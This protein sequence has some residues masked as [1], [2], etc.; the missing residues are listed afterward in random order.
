MD[1]LTHTLFALT[2]ART[3][4]G[5]FGRGT[6][7]ALVLAS[8]APDIDII[9]ASRGAVSY[10]EWHRGPTHGPLA[11]I[12]LGVAVAGMVAAGTRLF[13]GRGRPAS[14]PALVAVSAIG[15]ITHVLMDLPTIYGTRLLSPFD[16][17]WFAVDWMPIV[18]V[19]LLAV[20]AI[21]LVISSRSARG[22][23]GG[24][25]EGARAWSAAVVL[26]LVGC[27]YGLRASTHARA[28]AIAERWLPPQ[29]DDGAAR[30]AIDSWP[31]PAPAPNRSSTAP[32][33]ACLIDV[34]AL[35]SFV[36]PFRWQIVARSAGQ[37]DLADIDLWNVEPL[38]ALPAPRFSTLPPAPHADRY[39][40]ASGPSRVARV[41]LD[42]ARF[43]TE[44][45]SSDGT[46][47][48]LRWRDV[49]FLT[50]PVRPGRGVPDM[51]SVQLQVG[52]DNRLLEERLGR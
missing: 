50:P 20:L 44:A 18:D 31:R 22:A 29:C 3:P 49:R 36:S 48:T 37:Y 14:L 11:V 27:N 17:R 23:K 21:G 1:N 19:Y 8:N 32:A 9:A 7:S 47:T 10:L 6:T 12:G 24:R 4:L 39:R 15:I 5:R 16:W 51:F 28:L 42:F 45:A 33:S 35:P 13:R 46:I 43:P 25:S 2:L 30:P 40:A 41:F 52:P 38:A 26:I 34:A